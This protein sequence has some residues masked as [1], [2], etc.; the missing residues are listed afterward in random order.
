MLREPRVQQRLEPAVVLH[1]L[2]QRVADDAD[3]VARRAARTDRPQ[4]PR[5]GTVQI[6]SDKRSKCS[7]SKRLGHGQI[8]LQLV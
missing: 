4:R 1:P 8:L 3:V 7:Q 5:A 2:G 6:S